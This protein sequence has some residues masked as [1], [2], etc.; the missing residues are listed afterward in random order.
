M[1]GGEGVDLRALLYVLIFSVRLLDESL[2]LELRFC[3]RSRTW[4]WLVEALV[5]A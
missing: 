4:S 1:S 3:K 2:I 5:A